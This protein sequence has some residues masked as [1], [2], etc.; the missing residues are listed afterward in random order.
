VTDLLAAERIERVSVDVVD[1][2]REFFAPVDADVI[3]GLLARYRVE[4]AKVERVA[5][6]VNSPEYSGAVAYFLAG[7]RDDFRAHSMPNVE[8]LF[9]VGNAIF[10]LNSRYWGD[11]L[12][13]TDVYDCMPQARRDYWNAQLQGKAS[14]ANSHSGEPIP[15]LPDFEEDTV[16]NTLGDLLRQRATF[17][18]ERVDG[19]FRGLSGE[20]VTNSPAAFGKRMIIGYMLSYGSIRHERAGLIN[21]LRCVIAKFMGR[22]EPKHNASEV[23]V[24][25]MY[26]CT[27]QWVSIDGGTLR[28]R[29]YKKGTAHLEVHP[30]M[31]W[32][33]NQVLASLYPMAIPAEH[34]AQPRKAT[35]TFLMMGRPLPFATLELL[36]SGLRSSGAR[37][38]AATAFAFDYGAKEFRAAY[39]DACSVLAALGG[40]P[41]KD[42]GFAFDYPIEDVLRAVIISGCLPD[43]KAH[44]FYP[45]PQRL[46][47][48]A[49][50]LAA[51]G[52]EDLV[53]EPSAGQGNLAEYLPKDRTTCVEISPLHCAVLKPPFADGRAKAHVEHAA[54]LVKPGGRLVAILPASARGK[55]WI[56]NGWSYSWSTVLEREFAGTSTAVVILRAVRS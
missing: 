43:Q 8:S 34:R 1:D 24:R 45:T 55:E 47:R 15:P 32:R 26:R 41:G 18:A 11:A 35:K 42:G 29:V 20:H 30:D 22:D 2:G 48:M 31:A 37:N 44:Q 27:G 23:L 51:I 6:V 53:L 13:L 10:A 28:I 56:G 5:A 36:A 4:R 7:A 40:T 50:E 21:D 54:S 9:A 3:D 16:R 19:I 14:L 49:A 25:E 46:A 17:F 38:R 39:S 33:L 52:D 12:S